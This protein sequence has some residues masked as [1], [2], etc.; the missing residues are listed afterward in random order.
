MMSEVIERP[1]TFTDKAKASQAGILGQAVMRA[2]LK[3]AAEAVQAGLP[4]EPYA[5]LRVSQTR[6]DV[7]RVRKLLHVATDAQEIDR[8]TAA[9]AKLTEMER[10]LSGRPLP[11]TL[12][13][14]PTKT[15]MPQFNGPE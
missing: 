12:K 7:A 4:E 1:P 13:P 8:L 3:Q 5:R 15:K 6:E 2:K 11:G 14:T 9:L 10:T